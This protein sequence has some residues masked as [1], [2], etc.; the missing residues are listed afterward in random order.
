MFKPYVVRIV[1]RRRKVGKTALGTAVAR[2]LVELGYSVS[3]VK[4]VG[5]RFDV[6]D[7]DSAR[8]LS[9]GVER[10][11]VS[12]HGILAIYIPR[13][14]D[15]LARVLG[16][17][18]TPIVV[19]EG[20]SRSTIGDAIA[21]VGGVEDLEYAKQVQG[22]IAIA[23]HTE[24]F[25]DRVVGLDVEVVDVGDVERIVEIIIG[26]AKEK[27]YEQLPKTDCGMCGYSGC[28]EFTEAYLHGEAGVCPLIADI[29]LKVDGKN[30]P[31][32]PFVKNVLR[33]IIGGFVKTLKNIPKDY[34][35]VEITVE[36]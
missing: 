9:T 28:M 29:V 14:V 27:I 10:V 21:V 32:N 5:H 8:Y 3:V 1:S 20:F 15:D 22:L 13:H 18:R 33:G 7:K 2:R 4:H 23:T 19:V 25:T 31:M 12:G 35:R 11:V 6:E 16:F 34:K 24:G 36:F 26:R 17:T 30:I